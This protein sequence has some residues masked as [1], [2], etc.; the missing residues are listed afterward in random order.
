MEFGV[1]ANGPFR[2]EIGPS[3][4]NTWQTELALLNGKT[5]LSG[6]HKSGRP[7]KERSFSG[8]HTVPSVKHRNFLSQTGHSMVCQGLSQANTGPLDRQ[9][10]IPQ[11]H[12]PSRAD[13]VLSWADRGLQWNKRESLKADRMPSGLLDRSEALSDQN[14]A[15]S[16]QQRSFSGR[17]KGFLNQTQACSSLWSANITPGQFRANSTR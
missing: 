15:W 14:R 5:V 13:G 2:G 9:R 3:E 10:T 1:S 17:D 16:G 6:Q 4:G 8:R 12:G 7:D 11:K